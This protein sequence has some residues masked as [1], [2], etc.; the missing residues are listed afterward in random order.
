LQRLRQ[1]MLSL[2]PLPAFA[3][4]THGSCIL[5]HCAG[6]TPMWP[7]NARWNAASD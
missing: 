5:R 4:G 2:L 1:H 3:G 6:V 7:L